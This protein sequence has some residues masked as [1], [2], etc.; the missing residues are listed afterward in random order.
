VSS[1]GLEADRTVIDLGGDR[2]VGY[3]NS[4]LLHVTDTVRMHVSEVPNGLKGL[5]GRVV[6]LPSDIFI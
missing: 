1:L 6:D 5:T 4:E 3:P 2:K